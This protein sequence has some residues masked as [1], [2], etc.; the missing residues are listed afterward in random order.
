[1]RSARDSTPAP[2]CDRDGN[3]DDEQMDG[4]RKAR[5]ST[6]AP[7]CGSDGNDNDD[8]EMENDQGAPEADPSDMALS[9]TT[10]PSP[11]SSPPTITTYVPVPP[12]K[13]ILVDNASHLTLTTRVI[14]DEDGR[15][16]VQGSP[17]GH[18]LDAVNKPIQEL[19]NAVEAQESVK[20][21]KQL[22]KEKK[23]NRGLIDLN[24]T[25]KSWD[26]KLADMR[27]NE[28]NPSQW[29]N[30]TWGPPIYNPRA[31]RP[32]NNGNRHP[33]S[34]LELSKQYGWKEDN[35]SG[36][37]TTPTAL[38]PSGAGATSAKR[39]SVDHGVAES[40]GKRPKI[41]LK[42]TN[43]APRPSPPKVGAK[44]HKL[45]TTPQPTA[46][47]RVTFCTNC[48]T[49]ESEIFPQP[50][51]VC[52]C[53]REAYCSR[54]CEQDRAPAH[55]K[56]CKPQPTAEGRITFCSTCK[57][58]ESVHALYMCDCGKAAYCTR[59][60]EVYLAP[61]HQK[62]CKVGNSAKEQADDDADLSH[63]SI[64]DDPRNYLPDDAD[65]MLVDTTSP[66]YS[67]S[68]SSGSPGPSRA[69]NP[70]LP[71]AIPIGPTQ[72][73]HRILDYRLTINRYLEYLIPRN[74]FEPV[75]RPAEKLMGDLWTTVMLDF[76]DSTERSRLW[77]D[78][79][80]DPDGREVDHGSFGMFVISASLDDERSLM[81]NIR[82]NKA[83]WEINDD[84]L[85]VDAQD[86]STE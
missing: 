32:R 64:L 6:P 21:A 74:T 50:L 49:H 76:W 3:G 10:V 4:I 23:M 7:N 11:P 42:F 66:R 13:A 40:P 62:V 70:S 30:E 18:Y 69:S 83:Q 5:D 16:W 80:E 85:E 53:G 79:I 51:F 52:D 78:F 35:G 47:G 65:G 9:P 59:A 75:W 73:E 48:R 63:L 57:M 54:A 34:T 56:A 68:S 72:L 26:Q 28:G 1:M 22:K 58:H 2:G 36:S 14:Y 24:N 20:S 44:V 17:R 82:K 81:F 38:S 71:P 46:E 45:F 77:R 31:V 39:P 67:P 19:Q 43:I 60:C 41:T 25:T 33:S 55:Q 8:E 29:M 84:D 12:N 61:T 86:L 37:P 15:E 27:A